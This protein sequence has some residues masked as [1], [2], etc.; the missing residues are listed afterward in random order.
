MEETRMRELDGPRRA[1]YIRNSCGRGA[2]TGLCGGWQIFLKG[3]VLKMSL[4]NKAKKTAK[5]LE[6]ERTRADAIDKFE[7]G[8]SRSKERTLEAERRADSLSMSYRPVQ[9][10]TGKWNF[11]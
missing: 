8:E 9:P 3:N 2:H 7:E 6:P 1:C 10:H 4:E 11:Y 5:A